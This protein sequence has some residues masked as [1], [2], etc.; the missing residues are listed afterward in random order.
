MTYRFR[1]ATAFFLLFTL[2]NQISIADEVDDAIVTLT[3]GS[4]LKATPDSIAAQL[5]SWIAVKSAEKSAE[6]GW[7]F[8]GKNAQN[9]LVEAVFFPDEGQNWLFSGLSV[10]LFS[11]EQ[12]CQATYQKLAKQ[13]T[14]QLGTAHVE[15]GNDSSETE[16]F[17]VLKSDAQWG[18]W[19]TTVVAAHP[20]TGEREC[21]VVAS[22][23][24]G[25]DSYLSDD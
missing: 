17:W 20:Q 3:R 24:F 8:K 15:Q 11:G 10:T 18:V 1:V 25:A 7:V 19:V 13:L 6:D 12:R 16:R 4:L 23:A 21:G 14:K 5:K 2:L 9:S 22:L